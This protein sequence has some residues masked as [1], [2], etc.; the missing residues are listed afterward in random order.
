M[1]EEALAGIRQVVRQVGLLQARAEFC[2]QFAA[3]GASGRCHVRKQQCMCRISVE[4]GFDQGLGSARL[5]DRDDMQPEQQSGWSGRVKAVTFTQMIQV[6]GLPAR[7]PS[8]AQ[9]D[10]RLGKIKEKR[11]DDASHQRKA[12]SAAASTA[13]ALGVCPGRP[14]LRKN[15]LPKTPVSS[16][17]VVM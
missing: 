6:L 5:T 16:G 10:Q 3:G 9:P 17:S 11:V 8:E 15:P 12:C 7:A 14:R 13:S 4:Q 2:D 1:V